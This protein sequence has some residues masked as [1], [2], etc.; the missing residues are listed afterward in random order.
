MYNENETYS[1]VSNLTGEIVN[2]INPGDSIKRGKNKTDCDLYYGYN[3]DKKFVKLYTGVSNVLADLLTGTELK[4]V[5]KL[6]NLICYEDYILRK[7][8]HHNGE[9]LDLKQISEI[10]DMNYNTLRGIMRSLYK[11]GVFGVFKSGEVFTEE[12]Y[13]AI[14]ANPDI[15]GIGRNVMYNT[16][17]LFEKTK[18]KEYLVSKK[19]W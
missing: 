18:W 1:V 4:V 17:A 3:S 8:G 11:K 2:Q 5:I 19:I 9:I 14:V 6:T 15:F 7:G 10:L 16:V 13:N 12:L